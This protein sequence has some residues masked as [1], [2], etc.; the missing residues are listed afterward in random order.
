MDEPKTSSVV[1]S[2][3]RTESKSDASWLM[4]WGAAGQL[5]WMIALPAIFF[6][7]GGVWLDKQFVTSPIF[8]IVGIPLALLVSAMGVWRMIKQ[9]NKK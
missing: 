4:V 7:L 2:R 5:A 6:V 8:V 9:V 1:S 3:P